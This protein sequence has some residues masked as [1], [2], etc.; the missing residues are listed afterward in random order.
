M[1]RVVMLV[2]LVGAVV[3]GCSD[4]GIY[5]PT[6]PTDAGVDVELPSPEPTM[7]AGAAE[8]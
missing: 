7:E 1:I 2:A 8:P 3:M 4:D 6:E 5:E